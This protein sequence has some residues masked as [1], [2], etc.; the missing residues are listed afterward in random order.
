MKGEFA[1]PPGAAELDFFKNFKDDP[2]K[3][4]AILEN[5]FDGIYITDGNANTI[6][7]NYSYEIIS[8]LTKEEVMGKNMRDLERAG[9][10]SKSASLIALKSG[11]AATLDQEFKTGKQAVV[12][13][14]PIFNH[15][16][17]IVM[18]VTNVR[19]VS[20]LYRLKEK[21]AQNVKLNQHYQT[22]IK[23]IWKQILGDT[24]LVAKDRKM[25]DLLRVVKRVAM[26]DTEVLILGETGVGKEVIANYIH[27]NS[28]RC[29]EHFIKVNCGAISKS[30]IESELFGYEGGAFTGANKEGKPGLFEVADK[31]TIFLDEV[32]DLPLNMQVKLL[33]VLQEQEILRVGSSKP[34]KINVRILASTNRN[35]KKMVAAGT[36]RSDL[37]YRLNVFP[38]VIPPLRERKEDIPALAESMLESF[39]K[40]YGKSKKLT[41]TAMA[42]L[43]EYHWTGN[44][45]ELKNVVERAFIMSEEDTITAASLSLRT[46]RIPR[47]ADNG[48]GIDLKKILEEIE[49]EYIDHAYEKYHNVRAAARSLRMD[50]ATYTRKRKK[51]SGKVPA[52]EKS[53]L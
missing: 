1:C 16:K 52:R 50:P 36:F 39:N 5:S 18:V 35:L 15:N 20:E 41:K 33:R 47:P 38:V 27:R 23:M 37:Y 4:I 43:K 11:R 14:T 32:G 2:A 8:G 29:K 12:T 40:K 24:N 28:P 9:V 44:V 45:R 21:L 30:L 34:V 25:L 48:E 7:I 51:Y 19:D 6:L 53:V 13:S 3:L 42:R 46:P 22:E 26:L 17:R 31:G 10:I 49:S